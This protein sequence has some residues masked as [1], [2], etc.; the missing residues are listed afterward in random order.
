MSIEWGVYPQES[1]MSMFVHDNTGT[2]STVLAANLPFNVHVTWFVPKTEAA[3]IGGSFRIRTFAESIGPGPEK[4]IGGTLTV[5]AVPGKLQYDVHVLVGA[6]ELLGE[7]EG[8]PPVSG[9]YKLASVLQHM[10]PNPN[11]VSGY[12][13]DQIFLRT[14]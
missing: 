1:E 13:E 6:G 10:N 9:M 12:C 5:P 3:I 14:P 8:A 4:Q 2:P 7:G 11:E